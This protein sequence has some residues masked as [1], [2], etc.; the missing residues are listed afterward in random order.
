MAN[1]DQVKGLE[2]IGRIRHTAIYVAGGTVYPGDIVTMGSGGTVAA[3]AAGTT[4]NIGVALNYATSGNDVLVADDPVQE[5]VVQAD[6]ATIAAQTNLGLNYNITVGTAS[7]L[8]KRS[9]MAC[10]ASTSATDSNLP[11]RVLRI[12]PAIDNTFGDKVDVVVQ[13]NNHQLGKATVG[14]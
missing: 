12:L 13:L 2:P 7:T 5:F 10:D 1:K 14:L 8:Y 3:A 6:D 9:A 11:L 4:A